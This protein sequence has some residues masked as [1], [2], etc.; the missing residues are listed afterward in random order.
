[1]P[2]DRNLRRDRRRPSP[3]LLV[4]LV[5]ASGAINRCR[6]RDGRLRC[7][8][9][10][11]AK[12]GLCS[13]DGQLGSTSDHSQGLICLY[14]QVRPFFLHCS[15]IPNLPLFPAIKHD[16]RSI[17]K[18]LTPRSLPFI[19]RDCSE[20]LPQS[21]EQFR[22]SNPIKNHRALSAL[23]PRRPI[24]LSHR[25]AMTNQISSPPLQPNPTART[26]PNLS[27]PILTSPPNPP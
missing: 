3:L 20:T 18:P 23:F 6:P 16:P 9:E 5:R 4:Q 11:A 1:M 24:S 27:L 13:P 21:T 22:A 25:E 10:T 7:C 12:E 26:S 8:P 19:L 2:S 14:K 17:D 15:S